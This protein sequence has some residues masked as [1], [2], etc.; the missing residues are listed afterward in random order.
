MDGFLTG[1]P[2]CS[3]C[4]G[5]H[6][7]NARCFLSTN[8][9]PLEKTPM[10]DETVEAL[11]RRAEAAEAEVDRLKGVLEF[12]DLNISKDNDAAKT[13][14]RSALVAEVERLKE[15]LGDGV[16][17]AAAMNMTAGWV[18]SAKQILGGKS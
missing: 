12:V 9:V 13:A 18:D 2:R 10:A 8:W 14:I 15:V 7:V 11:R 16:R 3:I 17:M 6:P 5:H 4:A 1:N